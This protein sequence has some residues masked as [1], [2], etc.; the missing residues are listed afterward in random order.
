MQGVGEGNAQTLLS[1]GHR[2]PGRKDMRTETSQ[3]HSKAA[4]FSRA[5]GPILRAPAHLEGTAVP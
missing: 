4:Q 1:L 2:L 5:D 3:R